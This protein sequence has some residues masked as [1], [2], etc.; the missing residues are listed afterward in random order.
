MIDAVSIGRCCS[1]LILV[2]APTCSH[3]KMI[4]PA[5]YH[6]SS[7]D[8]Q[9]DSQHDNLICPY[10]TQLFPPNG[11]RLSCAAVLCLSQ[12]QFYYDGRR[13]LQ[14]LV[15]L[16]AKQAFARIFPFTAASG[17]LT[18]TVLAPRS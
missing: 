3:R 12:V 15:R 11:M 16:P 6:D 10:P 9:C 18:A 17:A 2:N 5:I 4:S 8:H 1:F 7:E 14:P 13:Q